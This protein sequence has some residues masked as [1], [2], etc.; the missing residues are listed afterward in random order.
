MP[1]RSQ[2]LADPEASRTPT[3]LR[4]RWR[5]LRRA[6]LW[7][8]G[9]TRWIGLRLL[10]LMFV[11]VFLFSFINPPSTWT[12][13]QGQREFPGRPARAWVDLD[14]VSPHIVRAVVA[15]EDANFCAHWGFDMVE[16]RKVIAS[17]SSRGASTI[18]QQTAKNVFLWQGRSWPRKV[19]ET[20]Y[21]PMLEALWSKRRIV[22]VYLNVAEFGRGVFGV[23]AAAEYYFK[24]TPDKLTLAQSAALASILPSPRTRN[25]QTGSARTR[26]IVSGAQT[27]RADGRDSCLVLGR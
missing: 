25:P 2:T 8:W 16:I 19:M 10:A 15:A 7:L 9:W 23:H 21:T 17:G 11:L 1:R 26:S 5:P 24:T 20:L 13:I 18:T 12:I 3:A 4:R 22:E 14:E 27:I 6:G